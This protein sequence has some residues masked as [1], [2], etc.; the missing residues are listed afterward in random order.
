M[1]MTAQVLNFTLENSVFEDIMGYINLSHHSENTKKTYER[2]IRDFFLR[3]E[4]VKK[5]IEH[6]TINDLKIKKKDVEK[7]R[8]IL[9][10]EG[11]S[12]STINN[13]VAALRGLYTELKANEYDLETDFFK[14]IKKLDENTNSYGFFTQSEAFELIELAKKER[15]KPMIKSMLISFALETC[16]R[17]TAALST[18]WSDFIVDGTNDVKLTV[19]DKGN[20]DY[21]AVVSYEFYK[22]LLTLRGDS[23]FV[24]DLEATNVDKM[25][26]RLRKKLNI[27]PKRNLTFHSL[28]KTGVEFKFKH[29]GRDIRIAQQAANHSPKSVSVTIRDYLTKDDYGVKGIISNSYKKEEVN[30]WDNLNL[31]ELKTALN[32]LD[33]HTKK[34]INMQMKNR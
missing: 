31:E 14:A 17:L 29:N 30:A 9:Q 15:Q 26:Q 22:D 28:R 34:L 2:G 19:I 3:L 4:T 27:D 16:I 10:E 1:G 8:N 11:I 18:K 24:F 7:F 12:N 25:M 6:L 20:K 33:E 13:K 23:E 32:N 21:R 5:D